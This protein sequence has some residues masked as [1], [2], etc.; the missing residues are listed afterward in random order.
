[1]VFGF[2]AIGGVVAF[3]LMY[4]KKQWLY[5]G[6]VTAISVNLLLNGIF[7]KQ[8]SVYESGAQ[9]GKFLR[10]EN[11]ENTNVWFWQ[12]CNHAFDFYFGRYIP[13]A[14][15]M[16]DLPDGAYMLAFSDQLADTPEGWH[17]VERFAHHSP[18]LITLPFL[19]PTT[20]HQHVTWL[21]ILKKQ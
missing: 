9:A 12:N 19:N 2:G 10:A 4:N 8:L 18:T 6:A 20:R 3:W 13:V 1:V 17:E 15:S 5:A 11:I 14:Y 7:Y 16:E 21:R